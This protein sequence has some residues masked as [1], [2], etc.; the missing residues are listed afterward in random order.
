MYALWLCTPAGIRLRPL[1]AL[2]FAATK[3]AN[4]AGSF[5]VGL[6]PS[7]DRREIRPDH[8]VQVWRNQRLFNS[9]LIR[10]GAYA[11]KRGGHSTYLYGPD[12][13]ELLR[14]RIELAYI[15]LNEE[16]Y[17]SKPADDMLKK[18]VSDALLDPIHNA[19]P[20]WGTR[21]WDLLSVQGDS[22]T[23]SDLDKMEPAW[24]ELLGKSGRGA[25]SDIVDAAK[26]L[27]NE[28]LFFDIV[29]TRLLDAG[30][31]WQFQTWLG[32]PGGDIS[33]VVEFSESHGNL[34]SAE[35]EWD[36]TDEWNYVYALGRGEHLG[37]RTW[38][39]Y[40]TARSHQSIWGRMET[41][42]NIPDEHGGFVKLP[43]E[44]YVE[45]GRPYYRFS[46]DLLDTGPWR[47]GQHWW[48]GDRVRVRYGHTTT[49]GIINATK[50]AVK[51]GVEKLSVTVDL[52]WQ[53]GA[54]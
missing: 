24:E 49:T 47:F 29:P 33:Q 36:G 16:F 19:K 50:M 38:Q 15:G 1:P 34:S 8:I 26:S 52:E 22:S 11:T 41:A 18:L 3:I 9:Y 6:P 46:G 7:F 35:L 28:D 39:A 51:R 10:R 5:S 31:A 2:E 43:T 21:A 30:I 13:L 14:R 53:V 40:D 12:M 32:Q 17:T 44:A 20:K 4:R 48:Y 37:R 27:N 45:E 54:T 42:Y 23:A 25:L